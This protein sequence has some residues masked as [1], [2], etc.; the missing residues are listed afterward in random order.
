[1]LDERRANE[2]VDRLDIRSLPICPLCHL[3]LA[4]AIADGRPRRVLAPIVTRTASWAWLEFETE[5]L[6]QVRRAT[7]RGASW[8][9]DALADLEQRGARSWIVRVI[10]TRVARKM[11]D[12]MA[13]QRRVDV[14]PPVVVLPSRNGSSR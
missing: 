1:M 5:L 4:L 3:D 9:D 2:V 8:A 14:A 6:A 13:E 10:V 11:A 7:M 12:D